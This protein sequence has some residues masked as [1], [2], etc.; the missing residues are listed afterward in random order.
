MKH[1]THLESAISL[2]REAQAQLDLG[3]FTI[4]AAHLET[5]IGFAE[6]EASRLR[7]NGAG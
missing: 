6:G 1:L 4:I 7:G 5:A 3:G 2:M